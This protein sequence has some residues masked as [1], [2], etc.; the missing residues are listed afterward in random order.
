M[1]PSILKS[2]IKAMQKELEIKIP[3]LN[4]GGCIWFA[5]YFEKALKRLN[6]PYKIYAY[7][8]ETIGTTYSSFDGVGHIVTYVDGIGLVDG[9]EF[10]SNLTFGKRGY[11][12]KR[13][14]YKNKLRL[15]DLHKLATGGGWNHTYDTEYNSKLETI[16]NTYIK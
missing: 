8:H 14:Q 3:Y 4:H 7:H 2:S 6:I 5:Y 10:W 12:Y 16:I 1:T 15:K 13:F 9:H 11:T